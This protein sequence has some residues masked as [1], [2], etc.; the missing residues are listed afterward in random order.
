M[1]CR[2]KRRL[3]WLRCHKPCP[4]EKRICSVSSVQASCNPARPE[5]SGGSKGKGIRRWAHKPAQS[6]AVASDI[7][8]S[9]TS[10]RWRHRHPHA[11]CPAHRGGFSGLTGC[12]GKGLGRNDATARDDARHAIA[13][14]ITRRLCERYKVPPTPPTVFPASGVWCG[15]TDAKPE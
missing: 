8:V 1:Q 12:P 7:T 5:R 14:C 13:A 6:L 10:E 15:L 9:L 3:T 4:I 2:D 11:L